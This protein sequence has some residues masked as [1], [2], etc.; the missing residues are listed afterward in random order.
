MNTTLVTG[1]TGFVGRPL[2]AALLARGV[3]VR[4]LVRSSEAARTLPPEVDT[5]V[6]GDLTQVEHFEPLVHGIDAVLH[7]A[8]RAHVV[9]DRAQDN[10]AAYM[11]ANE[12]VTRRLAQASLQEGARRFVYVSSIK[13]FGESDR[14]RAFEASDEPRPVDAYGRSKLAAEQALLEVC[15]RGVLEAVIVRPPL[16]YGP[17]VRANFLR[18]M[19]L[20]DREVPLPLG[21]VEN[22]R[23]MVGVTNLVDFLCLCRSAAAAGRVLLVSDGQ[24]LSTPELVRR[25]AAIMQRRCRLISMPPALLRAVASVVGFGGEVR[26]LTES[27]SVESEMSRRLLDWSPPQTVDEGLTATVASYLESKKNH[28]SAAT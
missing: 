7:L 4:A 28:G 24:D 19:Q 15:S 6:V 25:L 11:V 13:A 20:V 3:P 23:S 12:V 1:A 9:A 27:L 14:G 26:R 10:V 21:A 17:Q 8:A 18:I 5:R 22:R 2:I 16:V